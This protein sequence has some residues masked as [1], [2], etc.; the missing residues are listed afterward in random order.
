MTAVRDSAAVSDAATM[1]PLQIMTI[2]PLPE[3]GQKRGLNLRLLLCY[4]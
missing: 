2:F 3:A 4:N 1:F